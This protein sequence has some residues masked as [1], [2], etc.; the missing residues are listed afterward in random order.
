MDREL[1]DYEV[2]GDPNNPHFD[3]YWFEKCL[4]RD[5]DPW[6]YIVL[7]FVDGKLAINALI[8]DSF[9][10]RSAITVSQAESEH[11]HDK[12][13]IA[14]NEAHALLPSI[15]K[16]I[17]FK[18]LDAEFVWYWGEF[19]KNIGIASSKYSELL[20]NRKRGK[21]DRQVEDKRIWCALNIK[22]FT[23]PRKT[24][25]A[26]LAKL[27]H[28]VATGKRRAPEG[29][30]REWFAKLLHRDLS[31]GLKL[32][33]G[34]A[35]DLDVEAELEKYKQFKGELPPVGFEHY[36]VLEKDSGQ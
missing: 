6:Y 18:K 3:P 28:E 27:A 12:V 36:P 2:A 9:E 15:E 16:K 14:L 5:D 21:F 7:D 20:G 4:I 33:H 10:I 35:R 30:S 11:P 31:K 34:Y 22:N 8:K 25:E 17:S 19:Q 32:G 26:D 1:E 13:E 29:F 24:I 23:G